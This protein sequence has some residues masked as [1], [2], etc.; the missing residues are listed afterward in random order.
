[1][2]EG[3]SKKSFSSVLYLSIPFILAGLL[4]SAM[5]IAS[6]GFAK[7][8]AQRTF[9]AQPVRVT[10]VQ[11]CPSGPTGMNY[12][13]VELDRSITIPG[14]PP[15]KV[16]LVPVRHG[17]TLNMNAFFDSPWEWEYGEPSTGCDDTGSYPF[18]SFMLPA[19]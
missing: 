17:E 10:I 9:V 8:Q 19:R 13:R 7:A 4:A 6:M 15:S 12:F 11:G 14:H 5:S 3:P 16:M 18:L 2:S 1:M